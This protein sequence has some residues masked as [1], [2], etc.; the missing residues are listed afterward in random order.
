MMRVGA[1]RNV[2][3]SVVYTPRAPHHLFPGDIF[4]FGIIDKALPNTCCAFH[5]LRYIHN[6]SCS[7]PEHAA[8]VVHAKCDACVA[9]TLV[10]ATYGNVRMPSGVRTRPANLSTF[11]IRFAHA[12]PHLRSFCSCYGLLQFQK[13]LIHPRSRLSPPLEFGCLPLVLLLRLLGLKLS[14]S[15]GLPLFRQK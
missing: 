9:Q 10:C 5:Y 6:T 13:T 4:G 1:V 3:V 7:I 8:W 14:T 15:R 2:L 12:K 11:F